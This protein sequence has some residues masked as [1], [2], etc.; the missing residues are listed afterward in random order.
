MTARPSLVPA[1]RPAS[2]LAWLPLLLALACGGQT[3]PGHSNQGKDAACAEACE[4]AAECGVEIDPVDCNETCT[5]DEIV[6]RSGQEL[7]TACAAL[8]ECDTV[9]GTDTLECIEEGLL[10]LPVTEAQE[11]FC[12]TSLVRI[13]ECGETAFGAAE[14]ES[15]LSGVA[16]L[17]EEF[18][19]ELSECGDRSTC[20][21][22]NL[23]VNLELLAAID[24]EQLE[25]LLG[26]GGGGGLGS[27]EDLFGSFTEATGG[28]GS[29]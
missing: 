13:A 18:V 19:G 2:A 15:C 11:A 3:T 17:S 21:A 28:S 24:Q 5:E 29:D 1:A 8:A 27:L 25:A 23:C 26:Q 6:S 7:L 20:D 10:E 12:T 14:V 22:V 16:V 9:A 4:Q